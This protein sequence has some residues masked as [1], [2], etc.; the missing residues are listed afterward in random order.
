MTKRIKEINLFLFLILIHIS[1]T[2]QSC[3]PDG[4]IFTT[5]SQ[6]DSFSINYPGCIHIQGFL[7]ISGDSIYSLQ[8][9]SQIDT[10]D[11]HLWI[12]ENEVITSLD[13]LEG[14]THVGGSL[15][16]YH[17]KKLKDLTALSGITSAGWYLSIG[18]N[19]VLTSLAGLNNIRTAENLSIGFNPCLKSLA[20]LDS[21]KVIEGDV[22]IS[23]NDSLINLN[24][25]EYLDSIGDYL[26]IRENNSLENVISLS[27]IDI[28]YGD[29]F[30]QDNPKLLSLDGLENLTSIE[31]SL[32][33]QNNYSLS[34]I[35]SLG[36]ITKIGISWAQGDLIISG[37]TSLESLHGLEKLVEVTGL[38]SLSSN[39]LHDLEGLDNL[40]WIGTDLQ[41][42]YNHNLKNISDLK[43][44]THTIAIYISNND[45]LASLDG[46]DNVPGSIIQH[47]GI[48]G[49][50]LLS[51]CHTQTICEYLLGPSYN[52][53]ITNNNEGCNSISEVKDSCIIT[54]VVEPILDEIIS[55]IPNPA[56]N[57]V[58]VTHPYNIKVLNVMV[59]DASGNQ[60]SCDYT[61]NKLDVSIYSGGFFIVKINTDKGVVHKKLVKL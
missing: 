44:L 31:G 18:Q 53:W 24:G 3:L 54:N 30:I 16:I 21:L 52:P 55:L 15:S 1:G 26:M 6:I 43:K 58:K 17:N 11:G 2:T 41:I 4:I 51:H 9:L 60:F 5:Q 48:S 50:E 47:L 61:G 35:S 7:E 39:A 45:S 36:S 22:N 49:N 32:R 23:G 14:L 40:S 46:L 8:G 42:S 37:N 33:I 25:I 19:D 38:V 28:I 12:V 29:L 13:G 34:S 10:I 56:S 57:Y 27:G 59:F 20:G